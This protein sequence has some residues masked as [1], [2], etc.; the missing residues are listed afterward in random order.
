MISAF[1]EVR[2]KQ[3]QL[4]DNESLSSQKTEPEL[5]ETV[6]E[7]TKR[8]RKPKIIPDAYEGP[9]LVPKKSKPQDDD[10]FEPLKPGQLRRRRKKKSTE[11]EPCK[12]SPEKVENDIL[13]KTIKESSFSEKTQQKSSD[14]TVKIQNAIENGEQ[15]SSPIKCKMK[16]GRTKLKLETE[17]KGELNKKVKGEKSPKTD[18]TSPTT[19]SATGQL[20]EINNSVSWVYPEKGQEYIFNLEKHMITQ[21]PNGCVYTCD[22]CNGIYKNKFSLKRHYLRNHINYRYLSKAD[23]INCLINLQ[24][25][26]EAEG[27]SVKQI[28]RRRRRAMKQRKESVSE[29]DT[30]RTKSDENADT[31]NSQTMCNKASDGANDTTEI[32]TESNELLGPMSDSCL[33]ERDENSFKNVPSVSKSDENME[34]G[35]SNIKLVVVDER[36]LMKDRKLNTN[37]EIN[38]ANNND[39]SKAVSKLTNSENMDKGSVEILIKGNIDHS[40]ADAGRNKAKKKHVGVYRCYTCR[41]IFDT[42]AEIRDHTMGHSEKDSVNMPYQCDKCSMRFFFKQNLLRHSASHKGGYE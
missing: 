30:S 37:E 6:P 14:K 31:E 7:K 26:L 21:G 10:Q 9:L 20:V 35:M 3:E 1:S 39:D 24:Q 4:S 12:D 5:T 40:V 17:L 23:I 28:K 22:I 13:D 42:V 34:N 19:L 2:I 8:I 18:K 33:D 41:E 25:V 27:D 36:E 38:F 11:S 32:I 16:R 15:S 29:S